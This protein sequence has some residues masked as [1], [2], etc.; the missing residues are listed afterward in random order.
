MDE[1]IKETIPALTSYRS[2]TVKNVAGETFEV[3][4]AIGELNIFED[5]F[6]N[7]LS[8]NALFIDEHGGLTGIQFEGNEELTVELYIDHLSESVTTHKFF[9]YAITD[10]IRINDATSSFLLHFNSPEAIVNENTRVYKA[11]NGSNSESV[12]NIF[13][14][15]GTEK[16]IKIEATS[17]K[18]KFVM[19]SWTPFEAINWYAGRSISSVS[20]GS[21]FL[22]YETLKSGF[23]FDCFETLVSDQEPV[24]E[25]RYEPA[26]L[27]T[28]IKDLTNI[29]EYEIVQLVN[30]L[31]G[32][33][34]HYTTLWSSDLTRKKIQKQRFEF[35]KDNVSTLNS[36][37]YTTALSAKHASGVDFAE[38][39]DI[40]GTKPIVRHETRSTHSQTEN[41]TYD[42]IQRKLSAM[43]QY[44]G[45]KLRLLAFGNRELQVGNKIYLSMMK[46]RMYDAES[47]EDSKDLMLSGNYI[48]TAIRYI[49]KLQEFNMSIEVVKDTR[50]K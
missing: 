12:K 13:A 45:I 23:R 39:R 46:S 47:K 42:A 38:R 31:E 20:S 44:N 19:P 49:F 6:S 22:L 37:A 36:G 28:V 3:T 8:G 11:F 7:T 33:G 15:I 25:Y 29:K 27:K 16:Q 34:E 50:E 10:Y 18:F 26:G 4:S 48:I 24:F 17:G 1:P 32:N 30:T 2:I 43:R 35:D 21:Y 9:I 14:Y 5:I 41:Y 40:F